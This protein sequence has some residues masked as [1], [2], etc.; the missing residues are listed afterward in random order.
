MATDD[1]R[2]KYLV[3]DMK[4]MAAMCAEIFQVCRKTP[5]MHDGMEDVNML[6]GIERTKMLP[7][8]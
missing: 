2:I 3:H 8:C 7:L 5:S 1:D 4:Y 6:C